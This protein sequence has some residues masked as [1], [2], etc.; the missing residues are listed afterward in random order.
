MKRRCQKGY[1]NRNLKA[2][3]KPPTLDRFE[4]FMGL[5]GQDTSNT[6]E[7]L[8]ANLWWSVVRMGLFFFFSPSGLK[9]KFF[10][11]RLISQIWI[12][13]IQQRLHFDVNES[14]KVIVSDGINIIEIDGKKS[15]FEL[16]NTVKQSPNLWSI[17]ISQSFILADDN[18]SNH[19]FVE[20]IGYRLI[21]W[22]DMVRYSYLVNNLIFFD[23]RTAFLQ[24]GYLS[25]RILTA[26]HFLVNPIKRSTR[27]V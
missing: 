14:K 21:I 24:I 5:Y 4:N 2:K 22:N 15:I 10:W 18:L 9:R 26:Y 11:N 6:Y 1:R 20:R 25:S 19:V 13:G 3:Q 7:S 23:R 27:K 16:Q 12:D 8:F 17:Y